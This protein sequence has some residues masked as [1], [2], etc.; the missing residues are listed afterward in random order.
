MTS[1]FIMEIILLLSLFLCAHTL[2]LHMKR[3]VVIHP[4][5]HIS[6][7]FYDCLCRKM[8]SFYVHIP[9]MKPYGLELI[10]VVIH[11]LFSLIRRC[12]GI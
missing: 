2:T 9:F 4:T 8:P 6:S 7:L 12:Y 1:L 11:S 5:P 10:H 3:H